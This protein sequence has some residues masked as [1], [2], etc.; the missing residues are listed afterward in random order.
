MTIKEKTVD[1]EWYP[2]ET[3]RRKHKEKLRET[4]KK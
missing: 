2:P 4:E 1:P 3:K